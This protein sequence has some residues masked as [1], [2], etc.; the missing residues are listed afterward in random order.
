MYFDPDRRMEKEMTLKTHLELK[1]EGLCYDYCKRYNNDFAD[2]ART[3]LELLWP[4]IEAAE[5]VHQHNKNEFYNYAIA[6]ESAL[7]G[8]T[9]KLET[10]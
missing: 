10:L 4:V 6:L 9:K 7:S 1:C 8:L 3:M 5:L 2:G